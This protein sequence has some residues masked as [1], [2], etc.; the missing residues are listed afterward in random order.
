MKRALLLL[1]LLLLSCSRSPKGPPERE[2]KLLKVQLT[3]LKV[4]DMTPSEYRPIQIPQEALMEM[5]LTQLKLRGFTLNPQASKQHW[6][7]QIEAEL[8]YGIATDTGLSKKSQPGRSKA[9][10]KAE[11]RLK[12]PKQGENLK[13]YLEQEA[14]ALFSGE[15]AKRAIKARLKE[16]SR[17]G[18]EEISALSEVYS[19]EQ[20]PFL[21][22]LR[23]G[24]P[25]LRMAA[26]ER[27]AMLRE[28]QSVSILVQRLQGEE[29]RE[30]KLRIIGALAELGQAEAAPALIDQ[31][32]PKDREMLR[33]LLE[34]LSIIGG[35]RVTDLLEIL[36]N[37][38]SPD[39]R[40]MV[41]RASERLKQKR[42]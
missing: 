17:K 26:I 15:G 40:V 4:L 39:V 13:L 31:V 19:L 12:S 27:L 8:S 34:A 2:E 38:D 1:S 33:A 25:A 24:T 41:K 22:I 14:E 16:V 9:I 36:Q 20:E 10:L 7:L 30:I 29:R 11:L 6:R 35:E 21:E 23:E 18:A 28:H 42:R 32:D 3:G 5:L 37:H